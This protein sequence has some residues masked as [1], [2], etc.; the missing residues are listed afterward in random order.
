M[1][2]SDHPHGDPATTEQIDDPATGWVYYVSL[3]GILLFLVALY[4]ADGAYYGSR[5]KIEG[6]FAGDGTSALLAETA[7]EQ[8]AR[9]S[10]FSTREA[11]G[12]DGKPM[13]VKTAPIEQAKSKVLTELKRRQGR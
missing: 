6:E 5:E 7:L 2:P 12:P 4:W 3:V 8:R 9:L 13:L 11:I 1:A 10:G